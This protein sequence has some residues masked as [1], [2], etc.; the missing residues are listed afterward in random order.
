MKIEMH[1][2]EQFQMLIRDNRRMKISLFVI[3]AILCVLV[4]TMTCVAA[5]S[6]SVI[7][8]TGFVL[9]DKHGKERGEFIASDIGAQLLLFGENN[10]ISFGI[11]ATKHE[12]AM[13]GM[14]DSLGRIRIGANADI[15]KS[16]IIVAG[17]NGDVRI[18]IIANQANSAISLFH[19]DGTGGSIWSSDDSANTPRKGRP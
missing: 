16:A 17:D 11:T 1:H 8:A 9:V 10:L 7:K 14:Y 3:A 5:F 2:D 12:G 15:N 19:K 4:V 18:G 6:S 13:L